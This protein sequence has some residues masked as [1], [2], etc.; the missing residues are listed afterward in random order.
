[1]PFLE[2]VA[3]AAQNKKGKCIVPKLHNFSLGMIVANFPALSRFTI[4]VYIGGSPCGR[5]GSAVLPHCYHT[6]FTYPPLRLNFMY[7]MMCKLCTYTSITFAAA[8]KKDG[9]ICSGHCWVENFHMRWYQSFTLYCI[10][11]IINDIG[12]YICWH[13]FHVVSLTRL[14]FTSG[15]CLAEN[16]AIINYAKICKMI[17]A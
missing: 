9:V 1:M 14:Y 5:S 15:F 16:L 4:N 13:F 2:S 8:K 12:N 11:L 10:L 17:L 3:Q 6:L 7:S